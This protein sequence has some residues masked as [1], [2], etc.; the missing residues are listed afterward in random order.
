MRLEAFLPALK[1]LGQT[2]LQC[3]SGR[4]QRAAATNAYSTFTPQQPCMSLSACDN[5]LTTA[6]RN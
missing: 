3:A 4:P 1:C 2:G 6:K 5:R